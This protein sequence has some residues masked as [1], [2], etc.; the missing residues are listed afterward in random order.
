MCFLVLPKADA[1]RVLLN[2]LSAGLHLLGVTI[3]I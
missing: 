3:S 2:E 1:A